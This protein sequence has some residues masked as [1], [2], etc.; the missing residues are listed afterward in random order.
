MFK[1]VGGFALLILSHFHRIFENVGGG[2]REG[3]KAKPL[4]PF[5]IRHCN[6]PNCYCLKTSETTNSSL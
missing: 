6:T 1:F 5:W 4:D 2:G 3:V